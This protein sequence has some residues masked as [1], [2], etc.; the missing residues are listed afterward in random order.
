MFTG[1]FYLL[2]AKGLHVTLSEWMTLMEGLSLG[3]HHNSFTGFYDLCRA[4]LIHSEADYDRFDSLFLEYFEGVPYEGEELPEQLMN[5]L[6][7][8]ENFMEKFRAFLDMEGYEKK[9]IDEILKT[10][11]ERLREQKEEHNGG[12]YWIG[13][14]GF[15]NFGHSGHTPE[16]VRVGG[17]SRYRRAFKVA[18]ERQYRD[19]RRDNT[20]DIRQFQMA[21]RLLR[22]YSSRSQGEKTEFDV[23][24]TVRRTGDKGGMLDVQFRRPRKNTVKVLM[25]MDSGG[26][27]EYYSNLCSMLFQAAER[28]NQFKELHVYYFHN[29]I[30]PSVY[31]AP[32]MKREHSVSTEWV[33]KN[34]GGDY[35]VILVGDAM[36]DMYELLEKRFD[37]RS[38]EVRYSGMD[39]LKRFKEQY[40]HLVWLNPEEPP[41]MESYWGESYG[42]IARVVDMYPLSVDGLER[43]MKKLLVSK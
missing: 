41:T 28:D 7:K 4:V 24:E 26:S 20:L 43:A 42:K 33:L 16:G 2:R 29:C 37:W 32:Q 31:T 27:M 35:K 36:M 22:Q 11:E 25:L 39:Y 3:L 21:F 14:D 15:T 6:K 18:G 9:T 17:R 13:T 12:E 30:S 1:F 38:N 34:F 23:D 19:F 10:F 5:W 8:P 40:P